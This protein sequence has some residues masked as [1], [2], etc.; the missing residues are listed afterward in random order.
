MNTIRS[1]SFIALVCL[2]LNSLLIFAQ[3]EVAFPTNTYIDVTASPYNADKT[4]TNDAT[5]AI[6]SAIAAA[7][8]TNKVINNQFGNE[9][10]NTI[11]YLPNGTYKVSNTLAKSGGILTS[12]NPGTSS[13][14]TW[15][16]GMYLQG[17]SQAG[18]IIKLADN[19]FPGTN[20]VAVIATGSAG[21]APNN[22]ATAF[23]H[24]I[25][26][27]T[28][29]LGTNNGAA[30]GVSFIANNRGG[31]YNVTVS[32]TDTASPPVE[33]IA[34]D[35]N[36]PGPAILKYVTVKG[37]KTGISMQNCQEYGMTLEHIKLSGQTF[38]GIDNALN[39]ITIRDLESTESVP[40]IWLRRSQLTLRD[41]V[42]TGTGAA[43]SA[44]AIY[45]SY[46]GTT[47]CNLYCHNIICSGYGTVIS[48][49]GHNV[50]G[51][52]TTNIL[53][54]DYANASTFTGQSN[55][56][57][58]AIDIPVM[59]TPDYSNINVA[60]DWTN[61]APNGSQADNYNNISAAVNSSKPVAYLPAGVYPISQPI[62]IGSNSACQKFIGLGA[63]ICPMTT[64]Y[65]AG[66]PLI[67]FDGGSPATT[68]L[69]NLNLSKVVAGDIH[70]VPVIQNN[71]I[72]DN[73]SKTLVIE[74]CDLSGYS[75]TAS[76]AG[77]LF[78]EDIIGG[79]CINI[80]NPQYVYARQLNVE[81][82][83]SSTGNP[84]GYYVC[85]QSGV[86]SILG[87]KTEAGGSSIAGM[88]TMLYTGTNAWTELS[89]GFFFPNSTNAATVPM[90]VNNQGH[91]SANFKIWLEGTGNDSYPTAIQDTEMVGTSL[92]T[93]N[94][95][96]T[97][98][99]GTGPGTGYSNECDLYSGSA[100][101]YTDDLADYYF[102]N[103]RTNS[104]VDGSTFNNGSGYT[105]TGYWSSGGTNYV[106]V[107]YAGTTNN[108]PA[109]QDLQAGQYFTF[110]VSPSV[111]NYLNLS[112][113]TVP[114][115][116]PVENCAN[117]YTV[118]GVPSGGSLSGQTNVL[119]NGT[120]N[121][122]IHGDQVTIGTAALTNAAYQGINS[123][124]FYI[125]FNGSNQGMGTD[126][127]GNVVVE[128]M[129]T[130]QTNAP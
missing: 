94:M 57:T 18:T 100:A 102:D 86:M 68:C 46:P 120:G 3:T 50:S 29:D 37:C 51:G 85:N 61:A 22:S 89:G 110:T 4:G 121:N 81:S 82:V 83:V 34:M 43:S 74:N 9:G 11:V 56:I 103:S 26:N 129:E 2:I 20:G 45:T 124:R 75:N 108:A 73:S 21:T 54:P 48:Y 114:V 47:N 16:S 19:T 117:N 84:G 95:P 104:G 64:N 41:S 71:S 59:D 106:A 24:Y 42:L 78:L 87:Y 53:L 55:S 31:M 125:L 90:I 101:P 52:G 96:Y 10:V 76:G 93:T 91:L 5:V 77:D 44:D 1:I 62:H 99:Y 33:G 35:N 15:E 60:T 79:A 49:A 12:Q 92:V 7:F 66:E 70:H 40:A 58:N 113:I 38:V 28:V 8:A 67:Q 119:I 111:Y 126:Y 115:T 63:V 80:A 109:L 13:T 25:R 88:N 14:D 23:R 127:V 65:P 97:V 107:N 36:Y 130:Q 27:L 116:R 32:S 39:S 72:V 112:S 122:G 30:E 69:Q 6:Q 128:G 123:M 17:A 118:Y 98:F 105:N